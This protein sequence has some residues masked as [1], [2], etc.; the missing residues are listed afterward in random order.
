[1]NE[2]KNSKHLVHLSLSLF[3]LVAAVVGAIWG[4]S[5][6]KDAKSPVG[7]STITVTAEGKSVVKPDL[8]IINFSVVTQ[9]ANPQT[10]QKTND[11]KMAKA[12]NYLK[13]AGVDEK[14]IK[15]LSYNLDPQ[16]NYS[17]CNSG[18]S[19]IYCPPQLA[20]YMLTQQVELKLRD[21]TK[22]GEVVGTLPNNGVNQISSISF[23][24]DNDDAPKMEARKQA[25]EKAMTQATAMAK[26]AGIKLSRIV[27]I[28]ESSLYAPTPY[29]NQSAKVMD[30]S[31]AGISESSPIQTGSQEITIDISIT[32]E[33]K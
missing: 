14:D 13:Q 1:M 2:E 30:A 12:I 17:W 25:I 23:T 5:V 7:V 22:V 9:G 24:V 32:Y 26:A 16:Y 10:I 33:I 29:R 31:G 11:E 21:L 15:T 28:S 20:G 8:A 4:W 19:S 6:Y 18:D 3:L 27:S